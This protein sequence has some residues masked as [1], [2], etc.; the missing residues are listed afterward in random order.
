MYIECGFHFIPP[1]P[2]GHGRGCE[3]E[4]VCV[5]VSECV[6]MC[7]WVSEWVC[8]YVHTSFLHFHIVVSLNFVRYFIW[9]QRLAAKNENYEGIVLLFETRK[10]CMSDGVPILMR[11]MWIPL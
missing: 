4:C 7:V 11:F 3:C 2:P 6:C 9:S 5:C 10:E 8:V 1:A